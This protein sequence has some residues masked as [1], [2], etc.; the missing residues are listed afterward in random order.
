M[1][2]WNSGIKSKELTEAIYEHMDTAYL[3]T[4]D[5]VDAMLNM[6]TIYNTYVVIDGKGYARFNIEDKI[7]Y[8]MDVC[9]VDGGTKT[10]RLLCKQGKAKFPY[11]HSLKYERGLKKRKDM[12]TFTYENYTKEVS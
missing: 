5:Y 3:Y 6:H 11:C 10:L 1:A 12:R 7:V 9:V 4:R 2:I 8:I